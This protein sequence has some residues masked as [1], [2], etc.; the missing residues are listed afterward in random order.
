MITDPTGNTWT[1]SDD[2]N[3]IN[4]SD[5]LSMQIHKQSTDEELSESVANLRSKLE[6]NPKTDAERI[7]E[8]EAQLAALLS[9]L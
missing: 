8:L 4:S 3:F 2:G 9:R 7:A 1:R 5:G 6:T